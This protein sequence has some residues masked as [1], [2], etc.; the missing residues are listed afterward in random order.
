MTPLALDENLE[1]ATKQ[2]TDEVLQDAEDARRYFHTFV[3][4]AWPVLEPA[5]PFI[6]NWHIEAFCEHLQALSEG[7]L[8]NVIFNVPPGTAKSIVVS[9]MWPAWD[10]INTPSRRFMTGSYGMALSGR[11][12][13]KSRRL[14]QSEWYRL[15]WG[16]RFFLTGDQNQKTRYENSHTGFRLAVSV[17]GATGE[18]V[19]VRILDDPH[20]IDEESDD[21]REGTVDWVRTVWSERGATTTT[22]IEVIVMQ[23]LHQND[24][25]GYLLE[26]FP[27]KYTHVMFPM[28]FEKDRACRSM[29]YP[30]PRTVDGELLFPARWNQRDVESKEKSLRHQASGQLQQR[31]SPAEGGILK[32]HW[33]RYWCHPGAPL[34]PVPVMFPDGS[35]HMIPA[36]PL[37]WVFDREAQSWDMTFKDTKGTDF[38]VGLDAAKKTTKTY[39]RDLRRGRWS[40]T[41]TVDEVRTL[42]QDYPNSRAKYIEDTA[43]GPAVI[44]FLKAEI[45]GLIPVKPEG[46]KSSR[47]QA[48]SANAESGNVYLP[49]PSIAPWVDGFIDECAMF[50]N[51]TF[52]DQPDA[53]SQLMNKFY[54]AQEQGIP[55]TH[56]YD[57]RFHLSEKPMKP[58]PGLESFRFW[59]V[60]YW[61]CCVIGQRMPRG[62][63]VIFDCV[64]EENVGLDHLIE[65]KIQPLLNE[66]YQGVTGWRDI[67]NRK[68]PTANDPA[69]EHTLIEH[70]QEKLHGNVE[71]GEPKFE[72]RV[73]A[74]KGILG[75]VNR[76][77]VNNECVDVHEA[78]NGKYAFPV[79]ASGVPSKEGSIKRHPSSAVGEALGH[80]LSKVFARKVSPPM[81]SNG[82]PPQQRA[83]SYAV[84]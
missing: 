59:H 35:I 33:W 5:T 10:W 74:I 15:R 68:M 34:P 66:R 44:N 61:M 72:R 8:Q 17:G 54:G 62:A 16:D 13:L 4:K 9:V 7:R 73:D 32:R 83:R 11:D 82:K 3:E 37:P 51:G 76:F 49:H 84:T 57:P 36:E 21:V 43:N 19:N 27:E 18:R 65:W 63:I 26:N 67:W 29:I 64:L 53:W 52:D 25:C 55:I 47:V 14:I 1:R 81:K 40:F 48:A 60:D 79:D 50:P 56:E 6:D 30:D 42:H 24:V 31:P 46:G 78:L 12:A 38:V 70:V 80:G 75:I 20:N 2:L 69:S 23:R 77:L 58:I 39:I 28:R 45:P 22:D 71:V 41:Q